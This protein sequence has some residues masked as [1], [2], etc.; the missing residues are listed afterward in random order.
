[1]PGELFFRVKKAPDETLRQAAKLIGKKVLQPG[2]SVQVQPARL[3]RLD[4]GQR[5]ILRDALKMPIG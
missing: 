4:P 2:A 1:M 3:A 5:Q